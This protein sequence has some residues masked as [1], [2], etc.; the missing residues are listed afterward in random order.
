MSAEISFFDKGVGS[1]KREVAFVP[2]DEEGR[3]SA[4]DRVWQPVRDHH[5]A[6]QAV[7][8]EA[9]RV[10]RTPIA[11]VSIVDRARQCIVAKRGDVDDEMPRA[12]SFCAH[13]IHR[14][15]EPMIVPDARHDRRFAD[16]PFVVAAPFIRFYAGIPLV[17]RAGYP[18]G[19][20]CVID[21]KL[22]DTMPDLF[23][24]GEL[25][26]GVERLIAH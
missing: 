10:A 16:N 1:E 3:Q 23:R 17:D 21:D 25:A 13:A 26:R 9:A 11:T 24:L 6:L 8:E 2:F 22:H 7:V 20:L 19:A 18:I 4:V 14:P 12:A 5:A 15:G